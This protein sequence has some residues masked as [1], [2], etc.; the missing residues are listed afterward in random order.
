MPSTEK[1]V[2]HEEYLNESESS[3]ASSSSGDTEILITEKSKTTPTLIDT[4]SLK[5]LSTAKDATSHVEG[6]KPCAKYGSL[7]VLE[8]LILKRLYC[9]TL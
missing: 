2:T 5:S 8:A 9:I 3:K 6:L 1:T 4:V 7:A